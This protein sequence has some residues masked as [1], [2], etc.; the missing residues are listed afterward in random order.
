MNL[1]DDDN[2]QVKFTM[3]TQPGYNKHVQS[4]PN[5]LETKEALSLKIDNQRKLAKKEASI[6]KDLA[7]SKIKDDIKK[8][9][10]QIADLDA[11]YE[12]LKKYEKECG[13]FVQ[14]LK[15]SQLQ[16]PPKPQKTKKSDAKLKTTDNKKLDAAY[17]LHSMF[18]ARTEN[19]NKSMYMHNTLFYDVSRNIQTIYI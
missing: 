18:T 16:Q 1:L 15:E 3:K 7:P 5:A 12:K 4:C 19:D 10:Q 11:T 14:K 2:T 17:S 13:N 9:E 6:K 8:T